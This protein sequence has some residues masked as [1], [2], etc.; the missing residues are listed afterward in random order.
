MSEHVEET[1]PEGEQPGMTLKVE[2]LPEG[3]WRIMQVPVGRGG[4]VVI[5]PELDYDAGLITVNVTT[6]VPREELA[7]ILELVVEGLRNTEA[8]VS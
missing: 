1:D 2:F 3:E 8:K 7:E 5:V 4:E 6:A